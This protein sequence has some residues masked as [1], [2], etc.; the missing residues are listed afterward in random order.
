[1]LPADAI[2]KPKRDGC[3]IQDNSLRCTTKILLAR[4]REEIERLESP[5]TPVSLAENGP[6]S[7]PE[8]KDGE[9]HWYH[10]D[11]PDRER[12]PYGPLSGKKKDLAKYQ[13]IHER[14]LESMGREGS[15]WIRRKSGQAWEVYFR[16]KD[17]YETAVKAQAAHD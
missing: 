1:M 4:V 15:I 12:F 2:P 10:R 9:N 13:K 3:G 7:S 17:E 16:S 6:P 11:Q 5:R 14:T 8:A